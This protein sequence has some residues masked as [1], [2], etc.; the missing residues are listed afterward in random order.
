MHF[1]GAPGSSVE[2]SGSSSSEVAYESVHYKFL[3][4]KWVLPF[5]EDSGVSGPFEVVGQDLFLFVSRCGMLS[6]VARQGEKIVLIAQESVPFAREIYCDG[7]PKKNL[8]GVKDLLI[9]SGPAAIAGDRRLY[10]SYA[11]QTRPGCLVFKV[12][13]FDLSLAPSIAVREKL[14]LFQSQCAPDPPTYTEAGGAF[15]ETASHLYFSVGL[16]PW[17]G[18]TIQLKPL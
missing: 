13:R 5:I 15:A 10:L 2:V 6:Y 14:D 8:T 4:T 3:A 17:P 12:V 18:A 1:Q 16:R 7:G 11:S 9:A